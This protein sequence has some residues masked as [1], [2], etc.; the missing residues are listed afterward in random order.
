MKRNKHLV[1]FQAALQECVTEAG[2]GNGL[3]A[4]Q[5]ALHSLDLNQRIQLLRSE[6]NLLQSYRMS[7]SWYSFQELLRGILVTHDDF[8]VHS[9]LQVIQLKAL[10][11][12]YPEDLD[13]PYIIQGGI[14]GEGSALGDWFR[15][16]IKKGM[17][18]FLHE[19]QACAE[20]E[21]FTEMQRIQVVRRLFAP[22]LSENDKSTLLPH[23]SITS[24]TP[25]CDVLKT[26]GRML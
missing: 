24:G 4:T 13:D 16:T 12:V 3:N 9:F 25:L 2:S 18:Q 1:S 5:L 8:N 11:E 23:W 10:Q 17:V 21:H 26:V 14:Y 15:K 7:L 6:E 22:I 19:L 20:S